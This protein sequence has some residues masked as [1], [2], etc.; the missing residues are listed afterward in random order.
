LQEHRDRQILGRVADGDQDAFAKLF[1]RYGPAS[2]GL[3]R[4]IL[5]SQELAEE[6][7]QEVFLAVW[8]RAASYDALRGSVGSWILTQIHN[9]A[10]DA[11]RHE[12]A[13]RRRAA[14]EP[15]AIN[16]ETTPDDVVEE[17]WIDERRQQVRRALE[18]LSQEHRQVIELTYFGG[19]TQAQAAR[20]T[21]IPLGTVKSRTLAAMRRMREALSPEDDR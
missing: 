4:R 5:G 2:L 13:Q 12:Q 6:V 18:R 14:A 1:R 15:A 20:A 11:V 9:K 17:A 16:Q 7:L 19:M 10:V 21:G 8:R 3:A